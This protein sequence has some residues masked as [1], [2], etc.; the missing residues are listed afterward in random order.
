MLKVDATVDAP[1]VGEIVDESRSAMFAVRTRYEGGE[2]VLYDGAT[3]TVYPPHEVGTH[4]GRL[5]YN[6]PA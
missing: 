4:P 6:L 1:R 3:D 2:L 5:R